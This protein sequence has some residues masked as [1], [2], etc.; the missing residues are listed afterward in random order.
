MAVTITIADLKERIEG[1]EDDD[2]ATALLDYATAAIGVEVDDLD[3]VPEAV[4]NMAAAR[5]VT[6]LRQTGVTLGQMN[7]ELRQQA[8]SPVRAS[9]ARGVLAPWISLGLDD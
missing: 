4:A 8:V 5:I 6:W 9:G 3:D 7:A 2:E 1:L